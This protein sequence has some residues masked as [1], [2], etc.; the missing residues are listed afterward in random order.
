M[1]DFGEVFLRQEQN[2]L[3]V[4][5]SSHCL[6][7]QHDNSKKMINSQTSHFHV[8][9]YLCLLTSLRSF[10]GTVCRQVVLLSFM[11]VPLMEMDLF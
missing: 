11:S 2:A 3:P 1:N 4:V 7:Y 8:Y 9:V 5:S 10:T 6:F